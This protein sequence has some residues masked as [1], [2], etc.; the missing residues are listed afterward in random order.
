MIDSIEYW[1]VLAG[2]VVVFW[3]LPAKLRYGFLALASFAYLF[4]LEPAGVST[5]AFWTLLFF[6]VTPTADS[7]ARF[8]RQ[9]LAALI[10]TILCYLAWFKYIPP[11]THALRGETGYLAFAIPLGISYLTFKLIHY[12]IEIRRGNIQKHSV[13]DF[14]SYMYLFPIFSAGPIERFDHYLA[15]RELKWT[16]DSTVEG[17]TRIVQGLVK[18]FAIAGMLLQPLFV[19][20]SGAENVTELL[21][22]LASH[23]ALDVWLF[24]CL[25]YLVGYMDFSAYSDIAIGA[26]RLFGI[27]IMENFNFP[28]IAPNIGNFW[29]RWHMTLASWCQSYV[30]MPTIGLS[31]NLYLAIFATFFAIGLWHAGAWNWIFWGLYNAIGV[32]VYLTWARVKRLRR[33]KHL[34]RGMWRFA[35]I[36][37]TFLFVAAG[38]TFT[39]THGVSGVYSSFRI[40][41]KL[42]GVDLDV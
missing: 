38:F 40:F 25:V 3:A 7:N 19:P 23:S 8:A 29:K 22:K 34:D 9:I 13:A 30:Y 31:R 17:L 12:A 32:S 6:Y 4:T 33:W 35:G 37:V 20:A 36:P 21:D 16:R 27:R 24:M 5:L 10:I 11:L 42:F 28:I 39:V 15:H 26:S 41:A 18:K 14:A 1:V 2:T